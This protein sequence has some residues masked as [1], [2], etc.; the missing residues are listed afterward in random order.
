MPKEEP[1]SGCSGSTSQVNLSQIVEHAFIDI[2][3]FYSKQL[4]Q[5][6]ELCSTQQL[7]NKP[8]T[9]YKTDKFV[10]YVAICHERKQKCVEIFFK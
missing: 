8:K 3:I 10:I 6:K 5:S 4:A 2:S 1:K 9:S 7:K